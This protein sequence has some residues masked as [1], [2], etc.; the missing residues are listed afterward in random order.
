VYTVKKKKKVCGER[1]VFCL[2]QLWKE[3]R[4]AFS[5][6]RWMSHQPNSHRR[7]FFLFQKEVKTLNFIFFSKSKALQKREKSEN[8]H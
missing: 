2:N 4:G 5:A 1:G 7:A 8:R 3:R 6:S